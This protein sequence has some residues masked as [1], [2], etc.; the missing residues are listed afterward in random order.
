MSQFLQSVAFGLIT[1]SVLAIGAVGF[2]LQA[3]VTNILNFA[4]GSTMTACAFVAYVVNAAGLG[5]WWSLIVA[6]IFGGVF[7]AG[8]NRLVF[9]PFARHG[10]RMISMIYVTIGV[11]LIIQYA[12]EAIWGPDFYT[13]RQSSGPA[14]H[15][16]SATFTTSQVVILGIA[17][18]A[19]LAVHL[20]LTRT[21]LG[22]AMRATSVNRDLARSSGINTERVVDVAWALSGVLC[23]IAGVVLAVNTFTY[24]YTLGDEF[25]VIIFAAAVL[26]GVG[27]PYG[28]MLGALVIG[29]VSE[30]AAD[31]THPQ[32]KDV[33][34]FGILVLVLLIRPQGVFA[35]LA[36]R[37]SAVQ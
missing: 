6:A 30:V 21:R 36:G 24:T 28:A 17:I 16:L 11:G 10:T 7:T 35:E 33:I 4:Y 37:R 14:F 1:A 15:A 19:M 2:T 29:V 13:Y 12:V 5:I 23:G 22:T 27:Q 25:I 9:V 3:G 20:L 18:A 32:F 8:L 26:G 31:F 34:A